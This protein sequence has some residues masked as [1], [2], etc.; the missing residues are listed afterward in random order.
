MRS[1]WSRLARGRNNK[2]TEWELP[3]RVRLCERGEPV[4]ET[5]REIIIC[6]G[7]SPTATAP[8]ECN[9]PLRRPDGCWPLALGS[10][11]SQHCQSATLCSA[12]R[13]SRPCLCCAVCS[14][15]S[16]IRSVPRLQCIRSAIIRP[17]GYGFCRV[18]HRQMSVCPCAIEGSERHGCLRASTKH[19]DLLA[20]QGQGG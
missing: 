13:C 16:E 8:Q 2:T 20:L 12:R 3:L 17:V 9:R 4:T 6:R 7:L 1:Q 10:E 18:T 19:I 5:Y 11:R 14:A 15:L